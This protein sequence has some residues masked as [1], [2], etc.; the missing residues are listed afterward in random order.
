MFCIAVTHAV[1]S[2]GDLALSTVPSYTFRV[3]IVSL[4]AAILLRWIDNQKIVVLA[5]SGFIAGTGFLF[6]YDNFS[7]AFPLGCAEASFPIER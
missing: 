6:Q 2:T 1:S 7:S 5:L 4:S 3:L